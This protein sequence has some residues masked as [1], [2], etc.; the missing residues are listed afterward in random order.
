MK[1]SQSDRI[2]DQDWGDLW[3]SLP[4]APE[5]LPRPK[6][7]QLTLRIP[8]DL[9]S[10]L[11]AVAA[12]KSL[13]HHSLARA[14]IQEAVRARANAT[15]AAARDDPN[16]AQLNLKLEQVL[17]D[18]LKRRAGEIRR[19]YHAVAR[20]WIEAAVEREERVLN[21]DPSSTPRPAMKDLMVLLLHSPGRRGEEA[22]RGMTRLQKLLFVVEQ[23]LAATNSP[24]YAYKF[25]PFTEDV[26]D[27][28]EALRLAGFL[29]GGSSVKGAVPSFA[30]MMATAEQRSGPREA[31]VPEQFALTSVGHEA[32]ERLRHSSRAYE[33]LFNYISGLREEWDTRRVS[34]LVDRVYET[35]PE[36]AAKSVI[37]DEVHARL[38]RRPK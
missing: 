30:E 10:R 34:D 7:A 19:P 26:H 37:K 11:K 2:L 33:H 27:A 38:E 29:N 15:P 13:P 35:W 20:E 3:E 16:R 21:I 14:W 36:Y 32:A 1:D 6:N 25:G 5:F 9:L 12:A 24:F 18:D 23:K 17:L 31:D 22:I 28:V 4:E 8:T